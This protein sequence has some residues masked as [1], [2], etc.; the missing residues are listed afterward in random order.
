MAY[1]SRQAFERAPLTFG[2]RT[3]EKRSACAPLT[4]SG[5]PPPGDGRAG[6]P[7]Q[8]HSR[9]NFRLPVGRSSAGKT[10]AKTTCRSSFTWSPSPE[11]SGNSFREKT[12]CAGGKKQKHPGIFIGVLR[13][14]RDSDL[15]RGNRAMGLRGRR[16]A[17]ASAMGGAACAEPS[18]RSGECAR[19]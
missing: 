17:C 7:L 2:D 9:R 10:E 6:D 15:S 13:S 8:G 5:T 18:L 12:G 1:R 11:P 19:G 16:A 3:F 4:A 14:F